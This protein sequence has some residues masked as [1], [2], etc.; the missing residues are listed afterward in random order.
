[1]A[2]PLAHIVAGVAVA[3]AGAAA[4]VVVHAQASPW[5]GFTFCA[6]E[7]GHCDA[8][9]GATVRFGAEVGYAQIVLNGPGGVGCGPGEFGSDPAGGFDKVCAYAVPDNPTDP[10]GEPIELP[11]YVQMSWL[12]V[13]CWASVFCL[14]QIVRSLIA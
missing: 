1:M 14:K 9:Q 6:V 12:V 3:L 13:G 5:G 11:D 10:G 4:P 8:P 2:R 7:Y